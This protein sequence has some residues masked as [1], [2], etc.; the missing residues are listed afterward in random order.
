MTVNSLEPLLRRKY[1][2]KIFPRSQINCKL[3]RVN[4]PKSVRNFE[5]ARIL[6]TSGPY[7]GCEGVCLGKSQN[8]TWAVS[9]V[10]S[11]KVVDLRFEDDFSLLID[12]SADPVRN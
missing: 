3:Q 11:D 7:R 2:T 12:L 6:I 10:G 4:L 1:R 8:G 9:P 5:G